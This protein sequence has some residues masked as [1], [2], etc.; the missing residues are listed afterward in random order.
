MKNA[1]S[2]QGLDANEKKKNMMEKMKKVL[3]NNAPPFF[4]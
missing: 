3:L 1:N 2:F 4:V